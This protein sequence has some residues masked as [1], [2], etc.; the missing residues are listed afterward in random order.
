MNPEQWARVKFVHDLR[1]TV[2]PDWMQGQYRDLP[3]LP[4][5]DHFWLHSTDLPIDDTRFWERV[6]AEGLIEEAPEIRYQ[7]RGD[8]MDHFPPRCYRL[9]AKGRH[10]LDNPHEYVYAVEETP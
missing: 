6:I 4:M 2:S 8:W 7:P 5:P 9:T 3:V 10:V 1:V